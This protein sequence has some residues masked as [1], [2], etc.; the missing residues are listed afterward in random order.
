MSK[1]E[2]KNFNAKTIDSKNYS[3]N[4]APRGFGSRRNKEQFGQN[5]FRRKN[6]TTAE[7][8]NILFR[9]LKYIGRR[10]FILYGIFTMVICAALLNALRPTILGKIIDNLTVAYQ[11]KSLEMNIFT[12]LIIMLVFVSIVAGSLQYIQGYFSARLVKQMLFDL[13]EDVYEAVTTLPVKYFDTNSHGDTMSRLVN[14]TDNMAQVL[15]QT[16]ASFFSHIVSIVTITSIMLYFS[17]FLTLVM[18]MFVPLTIFSTKMLSK[19]MRFYFKRKHEALGKLEGNIEESIS[20]YE[21]LLAYNQRENII[22]KFNVI[23]E[24][25]RDYSTKAGI[26]NILMNPILSIL[27]GFTYI[28]IALFGAYLAINGKISIGVIQTFLLYIRQLTMPLNGIANQYGQIQ[29]A[30]AGAERV[31]E[32]LDAHKERSKG[33]IPDSKLAGDIIISD[34]NFGYSEDKNVLENFN[35]HIKAQEKIAIVGKTGSGKTSIINVLL[36]FYP[37]KSGSV[38]IN[39]YESNELDLAYLRKNIALVQQE[40]FVFS[41]SF[42]DNICYGKQGASYDEMVRAAKSANV[43]DFIM[44]LPQKYDTIIKA[45]GAGLSVGQKQLVCLARTFLMDAPFLILDEATANVDTLTEMHIQDA[46]LK[47]MQNKTCIVIAHRLSTIIRMNRIIV[48]DDG[49]IVESGTHEE[50][51]AKGEKY[52]NLYNSSIESGSFED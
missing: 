38:K 6:L 40:P 36:N 29:T 15:S 5:N 45:D 21:T 9:L 41:G 4:F 31:F 33:I 11:T 19:R 39:N 27:S 34:L 2:Q 35:L 52:F 51:L 44:Q 8:K 18:F 26:L 10:K 7:K 24:E 48:L 49:K 32:V 25:F 47:L 43:H 42:K 30:L 12:D 20:G 17:P 23:N 14:D 50:L 13:R 3:N 16:I 1:N 46:I 37:Y 28:A 22:T